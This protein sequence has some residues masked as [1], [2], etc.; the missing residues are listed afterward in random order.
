MLF[1]LG[2]QKWTFNIRPVKR[3]QTLLPDVM[4]SSGTCARCIQ[5]KVRFWKFPAACP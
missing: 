1:A 4:H 2:H 3:L 5:V